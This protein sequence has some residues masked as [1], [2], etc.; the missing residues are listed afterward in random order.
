MVTPNCVSCR[1][2]PRLLPTPREAGLT[3]KL[4]P[5]LCAAPVL[6]ALLMY[7]AVP[8]TVGGVARAQSVGAYI[9]LVNTYIYD[10]SPGVGR[11]ILV[12]PRNTFSVLDQGRDAR[13]RVWFKIVYT[14]GKETISGEGWTAK[15]PH[16]I[17]GAQ[18]EAVLVFTGIPE[19]GARSLETF[20]VPVSSLELLNESRPSSEFASVN[21]T[22]V[23]FRLERPQH[24]WVRGGAGIYR[25]GK[26]D[27]FLARVHGEMVTRNVEKVALR[28]LLSG[29]VRVGDGPREVRWALGEPLRNQEDTAG[30]ISRQTWQYPELT[31]LIENGLVKQ[32]D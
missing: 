10:R 28:R 22:K 30:G 9:T 27:A 31:V 17:L 3:V 4:W 21:W 1:G 12:R 11:R 29:V 24:L 8:V 19:N 6:V 13:G 14:E 16:E 2:A 23:R 20:R 5:T 32:I 7:P 26:T 25:P 18:H 15:A